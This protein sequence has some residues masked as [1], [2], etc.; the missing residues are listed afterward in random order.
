MPS[1]IDDGSPIAEDVRLNVRNEETMDTTIDDAT[2]E[3]PAG[4]QP[5]H[6][7]EPKNNTDEAPMEEEPAEQ[8]SNVEPARAPAVEEENVVN[9]TVE[10]IAADVGKFR[11]EAITAAEAEA[12][13]P[14]EKNNIGEEDNME[15]DEIKMVEE[16]DDDIS[17]NVVPKTNN[18]EIDWKHQ[19]KL[20]EVFD[21]ALDR[22]QEVR[23]VNV[24]PT[25]SIF[26]H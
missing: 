5:L 19:K 17:E 21:S 22:L 12:Q 14:E 20:G 3:S 4:K 26:S 25:L 13:H 2:A 15:V 7:D 24:H 23:Q 8:T 6:R 1:P 10:T 16:R 18:D 11:D 9:E